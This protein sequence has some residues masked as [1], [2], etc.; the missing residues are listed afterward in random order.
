MSSM[1]SEE[2]CGMSSV[3]RRGSSQSSTLFKSVLLKT[4]PSTCSSPAFNDLIQ[5]T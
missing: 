2:S 4:G 1:A 3:F 5:V